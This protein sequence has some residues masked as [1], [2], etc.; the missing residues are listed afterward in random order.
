VAL[1]ARARMSYKEEDTCMSYEEE[2]TCMSY[3][4]EDTCQVA[5][6]RRIHARYTRYTCGYHVYLDKGYTLYPTK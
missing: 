3:E 4:E 2:D 5:T 1:E 6:R